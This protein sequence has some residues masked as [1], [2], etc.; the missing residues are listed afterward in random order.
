MMI[1]EDAQ[2]MSKSSDE[3]IEPPKPANRPQETVAETMPAGWKEK[4]IALFAEG[5]SKE[6]I[7]L[8]IYLM[9]G[10]FSDDLWYR[11]IKEEPEFAQ[12]IEDGVMLEKGAWYKTARVAVFNKECNAKVLDINMK[13]RF[14]WSENHNVKG[15]ATLSFTIAKDE[16]NL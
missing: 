7:K 3:V 14:G 6:E 1:L 8:E 15:E 5:A 10:S 11:W 16:D 12:V 4:L 13:N 9:R 2:I